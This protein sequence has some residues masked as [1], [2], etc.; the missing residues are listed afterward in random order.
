MGRYDA[1]TGHGYGSTP[2]SNHEKSVAGTWQADFPYHKKTSTLD[3]E[4]IEDLDDIFDDDD[5]D[6]DALSAKIGKYVAA[7]PRTAGTGATDNRHLAGTDLRMLSAGVT[8]GVAR[9]SKGMDMTHPQ[10]M[11]ASNSM[12]AKSKPAGGSRASSRDTAVGGMS[13][14]VTNKTGPFHGLGTHRGWSKSPTAA[15]PE[16]EAPEFDLFDL[17]NDIMYADELSPKRSDV[18]RKIINQDSDEDQ[19]FIK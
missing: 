5:E 7:D 14:N 1:L 10:R 19:D 16:D 3:D 13:R 17:V 18:S 12:V 2:G 4:S 6:M 8:R 11:A 9:D 15:K